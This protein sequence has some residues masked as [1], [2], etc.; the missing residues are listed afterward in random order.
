MIA[1]I[2]RL[3]PVAQRFLR[4][5]VVGVVNTGVGYLLYALLYLLTPLGPQRALLAA[6]WLGVL[7]NYVTTSRFVFGARGFGRLPHYVACY[8][9]VYLMNAKAL[10]LMV[11]A[12]LDPLLA[13]ALLTPAAAVMT[14][15]LM[16]VVMMRGRG[17]RSDGD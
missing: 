11:A 12:G 17:N 1:L 4:F 6:F 13:Q 2:E 3:P 16:S 5:L 9:V 10:H 7:W 15:V 8:L 14:F